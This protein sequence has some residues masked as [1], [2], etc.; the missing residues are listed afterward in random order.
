MDSK[1]KLDLQ[2]KASRFYAGSL[3]NPIQPITKINLPQ[4]YRLVMLFHENTTLH[5]SR[6]T[7]KAFISIY[8]LRKK[9]IPK[10]KL[11][12]NSNNHPSK[13]KTMTSFCIYKQTHDQD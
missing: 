1:N 3:L 12:I 5:D 2:K 9:Y 10:K 8:D 6:I 13:K 7:S 4:I 11:I